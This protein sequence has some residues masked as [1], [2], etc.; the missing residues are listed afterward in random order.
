MSHL[1]SAAL[2]SGNIHPLAQTPA[3]QALS[4]AAQVL[5]QQKIAQLGERHI[6]LLSQ[7]VAYLSSLDAIGFPFAAIASGCAQLADYNTMACVLNTASRC[8]MSGAVLSE[9]LST[10][11]SDSL[12]YLLI[13]LVEHMY[14]AYTKPLIIIKCDQKKV[15][16]H[17]NSDAKVSLLTWNFYQ[18]LGKLA[19]LSEHHFLSGSVTPLRRLLFRGQT[20]ARW[21]FDFLCGKKLMGKWGY[22]IDATALESGL[23]QGLRSDLQRAIST[24]SSYRYSNRSRFWSWLMT[25][26]NHA[27]RHIAIVRCLSQVVEYFQENKLTRQE[28][29]TALAD[30]HHLLWMQ[31]YFV[32]GCPAQ[33]DFLFINSDNGPAH[34]NAR[35]LRPS[36]SQFSSPPL[37]H[38][39]TEAAQALAAT[40]NVLG[41]NL[42][43]PLVSRQ[44]TTN[45][46]SLR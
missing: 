28:M 26:N 30:S 13:M 3:Q 16:M 20:N 2:S 21:V 15:E 4:H 23:Q 33:S 22:R 41:E 44:S 37:L 19:S 10:V 14:Q 25:P 40:L 24:L 46:F 27:E 7:M 38:I 42:S 31:T 34:I 45:S 17:L 43:A 9:S 12:W 32:L 1:N 35:W 39:L 18:F 36:M 8:N 5:V 11:S 29:T 6:T